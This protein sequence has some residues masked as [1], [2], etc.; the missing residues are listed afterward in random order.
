MVQASSAADSEARR[1]MSAVCDHMVARPPLT[2]AKMHAKK[3]PNTAVT[4][5][6]F[7][8]FLT[9]VRVG[10]ACSMLYVTDATISDISFDAGFRNLANF[11]R[12]I[13]KMKGMTPSEYRDTARKDLSKP[14]ETTH[15]E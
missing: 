5:H 4:G 9:S 14:I 6:K 12:H 2:T 8:E 10:Q 13:L 1:R 15:H 11:N 7:V 3:P